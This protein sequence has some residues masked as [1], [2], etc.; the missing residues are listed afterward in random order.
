MVLKKASFSVALVSF[1]I[2]ISA[3]ITIFSFRFFINPLPHVESD[4]IIKEYHP[5]FSEVISLN[6]DKNDNFYIQTENCILCFDHNW[7]YK[8]SFIFSSEHMA[9]IVLTI[10]NQGLFLEEESGAYSAS[11][12]FDGVFFAKRTDNYHRTEKNTI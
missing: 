6:I 11:I 4:N 8:K 12:T 9:S 5:L 7:N 3:L 1:V 10:N 2:S